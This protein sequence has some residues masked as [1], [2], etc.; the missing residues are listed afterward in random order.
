MGKKGKSLGFK[1][2]QFLYGWFIFRIIIDSVGILNS[3]SDIK[4]YK[5]LYGSLYGIDQFIYWIIFSSIISVLLKLI[6]V[7]TKR[8]ESGYTAINIVLV[9]DFIY[10][11]I[12]GVWALRY[13][14]LSGIFSSL[15]MFIFIVPTFFYLHRRKFIYAINGEGN[16]QKVSEPSLIKCEMC[17]K[18]ENLIY[19][20][21]TDETGIRYK[22]LC[23][24]C[25][26]KYNA[27]A[28]EE[29]DESKMRSNI[30]THAEEIKFC[31]KCGN[32]LL[33]D[34]KFC[35]KCG[36]EVVK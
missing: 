29:L 5:M 9:W 14:V 28:I 27:E 25:M 15:L 12:Y 1:W 34:S 13:R 18:E 2:F 16:Y 33:E 19:A 4:S 10:W 21:F 7:S 26:K 8:K 11:F 30:D 23:A 31:R 22:N 35:D 17:G 32:K 36:T 24:D 3:F 6:A 20:K